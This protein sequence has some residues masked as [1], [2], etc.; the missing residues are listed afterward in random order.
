MPLCQSKKTNAMAGLGTVSIWRFGCIRRPRRPCRAQ[1]RRPVAT[2]PGWL[3]RWVR[4]HWLRKP[5]PAAAVPATEQLACAADEQDWSWL[6]EDLLL[7]AME[8]MEVLD[9]VQSG[10]VCSSWSAAYDQ[11]LRLRLPARPNPPP[12]LLYARATDSAPAIYCPSTGATFPCR[13]GSGGSFVAGSARGWVF[14]ADE[15]TA[16][17]FLLNPLTGSRAA[18]PP[19]ATLKRV[20]GTFLDADGN[21]M[22]NIDHRRVVAAAEDVKPITARTARVRMFRR[23]AF[24]GDI[25]L[26]VH[27]P[28]GEASYARPGDERW[29]PLSTALAPFFFCP[30]IGAVYNNDNGLFYLMSQGGSIFSV[31]LSGPVPVGQPVTYMM[32]ELRPNYKHTY[33]LV[34]RGRELLLVTRHLL[35]TRPRAGEKDVTTTDISIRKIAC[36]VPA[37]EGLPGIGDDYA[38][39]LGHNEP[40]CLPVKDYPMLRRNCAYLADDSEQ[41]FPP[42]TRQDVGI[43]DFGSKTMEKFGE[44]L[45]PWM[46]EQPPIWITPS[47][48]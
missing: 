43:W 1:D 38:L 20:K 44:D 29:I 15:A 31:D 22:Y 36:E 24:S 39:F 26:L 25:V 45:Q 41:H 4:R 47:L 10:A 18:L 16:D 32:M 6:P 40:M 33:Y 14:A 17:P 13:A 28:H 8:S 27:M 48:Y 19:L 7:M 23:V 11:F 37:P 2:A 30:A 35:L 12:C 46:D 5:A 21:V 34:F 9:V 42:I 3:G